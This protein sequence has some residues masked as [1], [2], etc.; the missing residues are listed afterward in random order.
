MALD[1]LAPDDSEFRVVSDALA[2]VNVSD[3]LAEVEGGVLLFVHALDLEQRELLVLG[4]LSAL[5]PCEHGLGVESGTS[6]SRTYLTG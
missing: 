5:E 1:D 6:K 3:A 4:A 2:L